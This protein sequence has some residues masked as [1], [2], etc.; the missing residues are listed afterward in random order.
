VN[1]EHHKFLSDRQFTGKIEKKHLIPHYHQ[2]RKW[3]IVHV[4]EIWKRDDGL[5][6]AHLEGRGW[7]LMSTDKD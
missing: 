7:T 2:L 6:L 1:N 4:V 5:E 3:D